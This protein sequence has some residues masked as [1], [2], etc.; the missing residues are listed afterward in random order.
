ME[1]SNLSKFCEELRLKR[2][3]LNIS[4]QEVAKDLKIKVPYIQA[5]E[6]GEIEKL[7]SYAYFI[8]Y[9]KAYSEFLELKNFAELKVYLQ[10]VNENYKLKPQQV[11]S[12]Q[13]LIPSYS[14][15][16]ISC[17]LSLVIFSIS[18]FLF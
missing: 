3:E 17:V 12:S 14:V 6:Q 1:K 7:P 2:T 18:Y 8:G 16:A 15:L 11:T 5:I 10:P 13:Y 9:T 4:Y